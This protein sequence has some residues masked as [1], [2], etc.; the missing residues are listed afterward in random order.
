MDRNH[1]G[2]LTPREFLGPAAD[3]AAADADQDGLVDAREAA[4]L[5]TK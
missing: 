5:G 4:A 2:D 3:F 1:D